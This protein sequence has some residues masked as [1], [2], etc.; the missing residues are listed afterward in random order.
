MS[1]VSLQP[2]MFD[3]NLDETV[4]EKDLQGHANQ[5]D[6]TGGT[7]GMDMSAMM[8]DVKIEDGEMVG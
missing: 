4:K 7:S 1:K 6:A 2:S 3:A 5:Y 8:Q